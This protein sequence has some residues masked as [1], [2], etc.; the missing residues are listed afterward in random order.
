MSMRWPRPAGWA[1]L[2]LALLLTSKVCPA[3]DSDYVHQKRY[4]M[5]T[6][7]EIVVYDDDLSRAGRAARAAL[8]EVVRLDAVM[9]NYQPE[10]ELSRMNRAAHNRPV[11]I[12]HELYEVIEQSLLYSRISGG[13]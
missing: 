8:D 2:S 4:A 13:Q 7:F 11:P 9:S 5:G 3:Q 6:V 1:S 10:S 12:S